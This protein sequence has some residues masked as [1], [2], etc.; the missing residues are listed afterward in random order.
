MKISFY[1]C[2]T[3]HLVQVALAY[4]GFASV[5]LFFYWTTHWTTYWTTIR[6]LKIEWDEGN[7]GK[8]DQGSGMTPTYP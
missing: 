6:N 3:D 5:S 8:M 4:A 1:D 7:A 2:V